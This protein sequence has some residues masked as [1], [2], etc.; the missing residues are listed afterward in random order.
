[1]RRFTWSQ[2]TAVP[3]RK[4]RSDRLFCPRSSVAWTRSISF[5]MASTVS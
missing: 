3:S 2:G 4:L 1:L 5:S